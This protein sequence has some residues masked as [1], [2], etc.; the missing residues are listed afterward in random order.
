MKLYDTKAIARVLNLSARRVRQ[1][2]DKEIIWEYKPGSGL[3][4][5]V[6][7][8]HAYIKF[9]RGGNAGGAEI[10][11][12][13]TE[14][15]LYARAKRK[16]AEYNLAVMERDLHES[17]E[18]EAVLSGMNANF[19]KKMRA[20]PANLAQRLSKKTDQ[21]EIF[22]ILKDSIDEALYELADYNMLFGG[23][24]DHE[25]SDTQAVQENTGRAKAAAENDAI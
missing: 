22:N 6:Q 4:D 20:I 25:E 19:K 18:I 11:D 23:E 16:E 17:A 15:A 3:Y 2:K 12:Y 14:R 21:K 8:N 13:A 5:L 24:M 10:I 1:L 7:T 9:L